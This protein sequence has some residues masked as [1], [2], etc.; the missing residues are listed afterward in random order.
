[1]IYYFYY[2]FKFCSPSFG[3]SYDLAYIL[4]GLV[5][6]LNIPFF[7]SLRLDLRP[8]YQPSLIS[9]LAII[10]QL[11]CCFIIILKWR[12]VIKTYGILEKKQRSNRT[13]CKMDIVENQMQ[14]TWTYTNS[15]TPKDLRDM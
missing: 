7:H 10:V 13:F 4:T 1:M 11:S 5:H 3:L 14:Y 2:V 12:H 8:H 9:M 6:D 15:K